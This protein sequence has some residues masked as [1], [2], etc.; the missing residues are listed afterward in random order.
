MRVDPALRFAPRLREI[1]AVADPALQLEGPVS[2]AEQRRQSRQGW[3]YLA[4][5]MTAAMLT[6]LLLSAGGSTR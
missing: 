4:I 3:L 1:A 6:V 2:V 5:G